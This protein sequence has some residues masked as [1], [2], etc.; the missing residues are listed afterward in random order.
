MIVV[1]RYL[2]ISFHYIYI[3][4]HESTTY[5]SK[6]LYESIDDAV[7]SCVLLYG[8][9]AKGIGLYGNAATFRSPVDKGPN[10]CFAAF[11]AFTNKRSV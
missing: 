6:R 2:T 10:R 8:S 4:N 9:S 3:L 7:D 1:L 5:F 11:G